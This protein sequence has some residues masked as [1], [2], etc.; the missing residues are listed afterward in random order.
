MQVEENAV[1]PNWQDYPTG[2][3]CNVPPGLDRRW[4]RERIRVDSSRLFLETA[5]GIEL[6]HARKGR[7]LPAS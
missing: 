6:L 5:G 1:Q 2:S 4:C 3:K 7:T